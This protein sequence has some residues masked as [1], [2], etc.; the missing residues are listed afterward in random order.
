M[1][2]VGMVYTAVVLAEYRRVGSR[3]DHPWM[4]LAVVGFIFA[5]LQLVPFSVR[6]IRLLS[7]S[8]IAQ[9]LLAGLTPALLA[10]NDTPAVHDRIGPVFDIARRAITSRDERTLEL[11]LGQVRARVGT[12]AGSE[13]IGPTGMKVLVTALGPEFRD[14]G[15]IATD[16]LA[17]DALKLVVDCLRG[18]VCEIGNRNQPL[19]DELYNAIRDV[20]R[21]AE[22][23][24]SDR[25]YAARLAELRESM[26]ACQLSVAGIVAAGRDLE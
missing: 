25:T 5:V 13:R 15:R 1:L 22:V 23:R 24:F 18:L 10:R 6:T 9:A 4:D 16:L 3:A 26:A 19:A 20:W 21:E 7:P 8:S 11:L 17:V 12:L 2:V 14:L